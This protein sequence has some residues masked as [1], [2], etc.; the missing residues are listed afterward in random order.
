MYAGTESGRRSFTMS[1][2]VI[3]TVRSDSNKTYEVKW[4]HVTH[5][6]YISYSSWSHVGKAAN[7]GDAMRLAE[8]WLHD[9]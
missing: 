3:G 7:A 6:V 5:E 1:A 2:Q 4:D 9:K 8:A